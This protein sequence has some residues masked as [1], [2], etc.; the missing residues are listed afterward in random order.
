MLDTTILVH[1]FAFLNIQKC[2]IK[3]EV[4]F[5]S[6]MEVT[7]TIAEET[8]KEIMS[9]SL[10][11]TEILLEIKENAIGIPSNDEEDENKEDEKGKLFHGIIQ[12]FDIAIEGS[13]RILTLR[14]ISATY[15]MDLQKK[16]R[17][18]QNT[19]TKYSEVLGKLN[20]SYEGSSHYLPE[21]GEIK[22]L[23]VQYEETDF[24][25]IKRIASHYNTFVAPA[26]TLGG[27]KYYIGL[28]ESNE[29]F[30]LPRQYSAKREVNVE[31]QKAGDAVEFSADDGSIQIIFE[32]REVY[33]IGDFT[34]IETGQEYY[35]V[36]IESRL[37]GK[38]FI[39]T[40]TLKTKESGLYV[41]TSFN[42]KLVGLSLEGKVLDINQDKVQIE[43]FANDFSEELHDPTQKIK[44]NGLQDDGKF[45]PF[46][47][48]FSSPDG[49]G[50]YVMPEKEDII[51]LYFPT[52]W[53]GH[54][55]VISAVHMTSEN[56]E[57]R[58]DPDHKSFRTIHNKEILFTPTSIVLTN[59]GKTGSLVEITLDDEK[60]VSIHSD[61]GIQITATN[62][63]N[64]QSEEGAITLAGTG[65]VNLNQGGASISVNTNVLVKG[66]KV[67]LE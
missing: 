46:S 65:G 57:L 48:V 53:E 23:L 30:A 54:A 14:C 62:Q 50:W 17:I 7:G 29:S 47:T 27:L 10:I 44:A 16:V 8:M 13:H 31:L 12:S 41:A 39:H 18:F 19:S 1:P 6:H 15:L 24:Q 63:V 42:S 36:C 9:T 11:Q 25:F 43:V 45:F 67:Q 2:N 66:A 26:N 38:E 20:E 52:E 49:T 37:E 28:R 64:I 33:E 21:D 3:K 35:V 32:S 61:K 40:Y 55:Y 56:K 4:N 60:G 34:K 58:S 5:H 59:N 51:R 22:N